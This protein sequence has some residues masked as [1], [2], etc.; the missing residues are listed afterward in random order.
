VVRI[1]AK[2]LSAEK[3]PFVALGDEAEGRLVH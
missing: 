1:V 2:Y 3:C